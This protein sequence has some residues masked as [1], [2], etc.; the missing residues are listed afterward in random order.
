MHEPGGQGS[1]LCSGYH[2]GH[3]GVCV[4]VC[5]C[6]CVWMESWAHFNL[7]AGIPQNASLFCGVLIISTQLWSDKKS[8]VEISRNKQL[9]SF[10][11]STIS[12]RLVESHLARGLSHLLPSVFMCVHCP[13]DGQSH[14]RHVSHQMDRSSLIVCAFNGPQEQSFW[15]FKYATE[16]PPA[17]PL[18]QHLPS[19]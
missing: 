15:G 6:V 12:R 7:H 9:I 5:V 2:R 16:K 11:L 1:I 4:C 10:Q 17:C 18:Q 19:S 14:N 13:P 3:C 8:S